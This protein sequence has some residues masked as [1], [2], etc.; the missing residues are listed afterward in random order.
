MLVVQRAMSEGR[1]HISGLRS[2]KRGI[3]EFMDESMMLE[4]VLTLERLAR[5][6]NEV[7]LEVDKVT[8]D[9]GQASKQMRR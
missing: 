9:I 6:A 2:R 1:K 3:E 4:L 8:K 5:T 7:I